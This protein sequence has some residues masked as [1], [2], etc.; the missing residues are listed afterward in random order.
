MIVY[1]CRSSVNKGERCK[2]CT[3]TADWAYPTGYAERLD[4]KEPGASS[5][6]VRLHL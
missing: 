2:T 5:V 1:H 4:V 6:K 3:W